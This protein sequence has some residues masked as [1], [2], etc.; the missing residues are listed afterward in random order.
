MPIAL[1]ALPDSAKKSL[2]KALQLDT[3]PPLSAEQT[4]QVRRWFNWG[5][6]SSPSSSKAD[7]KPM[8]K[9]MDKPVARPTVDQSISTPAKPSKSDADAHRSAVAVVATH[10]PAT[11]SDRQTQTQIQ[12]DAAQKLK[13][14]TEFEARLSGTIESCEKMLV[15]ALDEKEALAE[16][17]VKQAKI[18]KSAVDATESGGKAATDWQLVTE[19]SANVGKQTKLERQAHTGLFVINFAVISD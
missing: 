4:S 19:S 13:E 12:V 9:P 15:K 16:T 18:M 17:I 2:P 10:E 5:D 6:S 11:A 8:M 3:I 7:E 1:Y 14:N